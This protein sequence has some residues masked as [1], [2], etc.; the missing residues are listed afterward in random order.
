MLRQISVR[1][2]QS[3]KKVDIEVGRFTV[4]SGPSNSGKSALLRAVR[5]VAEN[6]DRPAVVVRHG[7]TKT[8]AGLTFIDGQVAAIRGKS[9]SE[10]ILGADHYPK[11]GR[12]VPSAV[13]E[14]LKF[15][16]VEGENLSFSFQFDRPFLLADPATQVAKVFGDLTNV[17]VLFAAVREANR[18][19]LTTA[20]RLKTRRAD[21]AL[22][23]DRAKEFEGVA[24]RAERLKQAREEFDM[25]LRIAKDIGSITA[26]VRVMKAARSAIAEIVRTTPEVPDAVGETLTKRYT[27]EVEM[28]DRLISDAKRWRDA[29]PAIE[30]D[31]ARLDSDIAQLDA[32]YH[33]TLVDAGTCPVCG[34]EVREGTLA[35]SGSD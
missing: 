19:R 12:E 22:I 6:I 14:F 15:A 4:I 16:E 34:Q 9:K 21:L 30:R 35:A 24:E 25:A 11:A 26:Q 7:A 31:M 18:R 17:T 10:Y 3:L 20:Q 8:A 28:L 2:F 29:I 1:D 5:M 23:V 13:D 27:T 33:D 32:Q